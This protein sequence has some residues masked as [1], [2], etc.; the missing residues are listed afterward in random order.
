MVSLLG[1]GESM[2]IWIN[3]ELLKERKTP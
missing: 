3:N 1:Y 2:S